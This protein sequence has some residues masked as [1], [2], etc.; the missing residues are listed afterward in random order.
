M[1]AH[2]PSTKKQRL[3]L[4]ATPIMKIQSIEIPQHKAQYNITKKLTTKKSL[5]RWQINST[6]QHEAQCKI[7]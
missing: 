6:Q 1:T 4:I 7:H 3:M 2:H 5:K